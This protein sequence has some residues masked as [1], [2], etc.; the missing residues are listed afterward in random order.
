MVEV[1]LLC[2]LLRRLESLAFWVMKII[3]KRNEAWMKAVTVT[4]VTL[5]GMGASVAS[6][7]THD[8]WQ[9]L[10]NG[11]DFTGWTQ[12]GGKAVYT[13]EDGA[14]V[15]HSVANTPN[16][17]MCTTREYGDFILEYDYKVDPSLNSGVQIRSK[18]FE[19]PFVYEW[20]GKKIKAP[21]R[22]V[23]G[24]Q[25]EID[26]DPKR[27]RY[28]SG[29]IYDEARRGWLCPGKLGGD[30]EAFTKQG[31]KCH[32]PR[33]W[34]HVRVEAVG[35]SIRTWLNGMP[36][37]SIVD[38]LTRRG[39]IGLQVHNIGKNKQRVG[40]KVAWR[41]IRIKEVKPGTGVNTLTPD[42]IS[43]GWCMLWDGKTSDGW[44]GAK[45]K[46]FPQHGWSIKD[47]ILS[48]LGTDGQESTH[49]GDIITR[50]RYA[51]FDLQLEFK[52]TPGANSGVKYFC[53]PNLDP[54]TGEGAKSKK[55][56]AIGLEYQILDD[57]KHPDAKKGK[58]GNRTLASLY[59]LIPADAGKAPNPVGKWN[60]AR[61]VTDGVHVEHWLNGKK[62]LSYERGTP[63][64]RKLVKESKYH[65]IPRF[66]EWPDGHILL[67]DHGNTVSFRN[68]K[69]FVPPAPKK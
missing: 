26:P 2:G 22:R 1:V 25:I 44:R 57:V 62:V 13:V 52:I 56:S 6:E 60:K 39:L 45:L 40:L 53:Q 33:E 59:D 48:V 35:T 4:A 3:I 5:L 51:R 55:G 54:I 41:N 7:D 9:D 20:K 65:N 58:N 49:G 28:W 18:Y 31:E 11:K 63:E 46:D 19:K 24:Y 47:V 14:I 32:K 50:Q 17:F 38:G 43:Q 12:K 37:A 34:N 10:F 36:R 8:G 69:I 30:G 27:K 68:I 23:H 16:S 15:G 21:L 61:I 66:G 64:F 42:E 29:G 67:Q